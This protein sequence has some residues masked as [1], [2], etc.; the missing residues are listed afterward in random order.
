MI[1]SLL[2]FCRA[3]R[4]ASSSRFPHQQ[5]TRCRRRIPVMR[6]REPAVAA[7]ALAA[8]VAAV[9]VRKTRV[10]VVQVAAVQ[11][12]RSR[13]PVDQMAATQVVPKGRST[14]LFWIALYS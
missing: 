5:L 13:E 1:R 9:Q 3:L 7:M 11:T 2:L 10:H 4:E 12:F 14:T 6:R 8:Q